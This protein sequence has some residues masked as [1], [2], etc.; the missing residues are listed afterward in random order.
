MSLVSDL[1]LI[2]VMIVQ[3]YAILNPVSVIPTYL[4]LMEDIEKIQ[5]RRLLRRAM[6]TVFFLMLIFLLGGSF[7]LGFMNI[8]V[9]SIRFGGGILL[10]VISIDMLGGVS[11]TK[12]LE[13]REQMFVV[14]VASPLLVGPGT[15][16]T[17]II[18][19]AIYPIHLGVISVTVTTL[20][21]Y[22]TLRLSEQITGLIGKNGV[23]AMGR[24][25]AIII[26][27]TAAEMIHTA[28]YNWGIAKA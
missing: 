12:T 3:L 21:I 8:G 6:V 24:I 9:D 28:L 13:E 16:T 17:L 15:I 25:M 27:A 2:S 22:L 20:L 14:P 7:I 11:R 4:S 1:G 26:A 23:R 19:S 10:F 18:F 5:R